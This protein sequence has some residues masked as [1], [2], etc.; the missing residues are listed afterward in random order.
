MCVNID[1]VVCR[2]I[3]IGVTPN[4]NEDILI[5]EVVSQPPEKTYFSVED[6]NQLSIILEE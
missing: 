6:F 2:I 5:D 3:G 1:I 4:V